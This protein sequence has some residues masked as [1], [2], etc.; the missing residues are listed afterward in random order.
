MA[1]AQQQLFSTCEWIWSSAAIGYFSF[2]SHLH[3]W[4]IVNNHALGSSLI[5]F[6]D[7]YA[8]DIDLF[9][10]PEVKGLPCGV[11]PESPALGAA[12]GSHD[13]SLAR[14]QRLLLK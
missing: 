13:A 5:C 8:G 7:N 12:A 10:K 14:Q 4:V 6:L 1:D 11:V 2:F 9:L 3:I